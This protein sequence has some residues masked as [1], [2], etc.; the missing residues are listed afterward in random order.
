MAT[1]LLMTYG[2]IILISRPTFMDISISSKRMGYLQHLTQVSIIYEHTHTQI[3]Y[4]STYYYVCQHKNMLHPP[5]E[6]SNRSLAYGTL[7]GVLW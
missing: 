7:L 4:I 3:I 2:G 6:G 5:Q 1:K